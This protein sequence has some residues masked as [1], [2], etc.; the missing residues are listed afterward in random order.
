MN[1]SFFYFRS[2][3]S[4]IHENILRSSSESGISSSSSNDDLVVPTK[5][6]LETL[7]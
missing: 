7:V 4:I 5:T 3:L 6:I 1:F 2:S